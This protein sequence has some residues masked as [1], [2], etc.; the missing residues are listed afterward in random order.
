[1]VFR[2]AVAFATATAAAI[3]CRCCLDTTAAAV[4][5]WSCVVSVTVVLHVVVFVGG[6]ALFVM[7]TKFDI[8]D[9]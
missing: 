2:E 7:S 9:A 3:R 6:D 5:R 4:V 1:M 8:A